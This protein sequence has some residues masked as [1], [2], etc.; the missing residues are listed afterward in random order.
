MKNI[1]LE[2]NDLYETYKIKNY[3]KI[4]NKETHKFYI[5]DDIYE[6]FSITNSSINRR[7]IFNL[8]SNYRITKFHCTEAYNSLCSTKMT[9]SEKIKSYNELKICVITDMVFQTEHIIN[10]ECKEY[11]KDINKILSD[12]CHNETLK[13]N[14]DYFY[15]Y[16]HEPVSLF[17][18]KNILLLC[19]MY[20]NKCVSSIEMLISDDD[21]IVINSKTD[22]MFENR[23]YNK[24]LRSTMVQL[25]SLMNPKLKYIYSKAINPIS[26]YT[27]FQIY[28]DI[29]VDKEE[30]T[31]LYN[32]LKI[33][34]LSYDEG[35]YVKKATLLEL[36][37]LYQTVSHINLTILINS[38]NIHSGYTKFENILTNIVCGK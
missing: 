25:M 12:F 23:K 28:P 24:L 31:E 37:E 29:N 2:N 20:D 5:A 26:A 1:I 21:F 17:G 33:K 36:K 8:D 7:H 30:N 32:Y 9:I 18:I 35:N 19:L 3:I 14:F 13:I 38:K 10:S 11:L 34:D 15:M 6:C 4:V 27:L 22:T 16:D